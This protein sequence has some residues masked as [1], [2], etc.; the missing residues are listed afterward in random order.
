MKDLSSNN[1][2]IVDGPSRVDGKHKVTGKARYAAE[3]PI[4]GMLYGVLVDST[5]AK[6]TIASIDSKAAEWAPGVK[7]V[8]SHL[9]SPKIP[10]YDDK[11]YGLKVFFNN[12]VLFYGQPVAL[13][14]ADSFERALHAATLVKVTYNKDKSET[15]VDKN[16]ANA[17]L[18]GNPRMKDYVRG[19]ADAYK[20]A[21][22][23]L[24]EEYLMPLEVHN[25]MELHAI[26]AHWLADDKVKVYDKTQGIKDTQESISKT[27]KLPQEN[28]QVIAEYVG[29]GFGSALRTWPHEI[30]ALLGAKKT[31]RP[32]KLVLNRMQ[33]FTMVGYRPY[34]RMKM[35]LGATK[36]G[37]LTGITHEAT[38]QTS[39][40]EE[41]TEA[42]VNM[43]KFMYKCANANTRYRLVQMDVSVPTWMRGPGEATGSFALECAMDELAY[44]LDLDPLEFRMK[45]YAEVDPENGKPFS[46]KHLDEAYKLGAEKIGWYDRNRKP[47]SMKEDGMLVGYGM[48]SGTFGA[49]R[50]EA[51]A[52]ARINADGTL[53]VQSAVSDCGPGTATSMVQIASESFGIDASKTSFILGDSALP[54]GPTQGGSGTTSALGSAVFDTCLALKKQLHEIAAAEQDSPLYQSKFEDVKFEDGDILLSRSKKVAITDLLKKKNVPSIAVTLESKGNEELQKYS[55]YSFSVHFAK[56]HVHP[57]TGVVRVVQVATVA[58]SGKIISEKTAAGQMIG[59]VTGGIGMALTEEGVFD[60]RFGKFINNNLAD[61]HV[62]VHADVPHIDTIFINKPDPII[63]PMGA[64]GMGEI[65]LIGFAAAIANAVYHATGK[66]IRELPITPDKVMGAEV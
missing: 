43:S 65:A 37:K 34:T 28:V 59:G 62:P 48:S 13:V 11:F 46:S 10:G 19:E 1:K 26:I 18:P 32:V 54:P 16:L 29:G 9:N 17:K 45:N 56:V 25:P 50:W 3:H 8:I 7:A 12:K 55:M 61:Y 21:E 35:G 57:L 24:E 4:D 58:D 64:K 36:D 2:S 27:F 63:N 31:G 41:F 33:M 6:G 23:S 53:V 30:A 49:F 66:R 52:S 47:A 39:R 15:S 14:V 38:A 42:T 44:K 60:D 40:Y 51:T 5:I 22:V 20:K